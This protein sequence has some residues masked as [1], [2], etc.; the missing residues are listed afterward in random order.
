LINRDLSADLHYRDPDFYYIFAN[1][2]NELL[3]AVN[4]TMFRWVEE[5]VEETE[6]TLELVS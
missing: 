3:N 2:A 4:Y 6:A 1:G 5:E